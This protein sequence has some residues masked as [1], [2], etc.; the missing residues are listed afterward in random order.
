[1]RLASPT[2]TGTVTAPFFNGDGSNLTNIIATT[3]ENSYNSEVIDSS[4]YSNAVYPTYVTSTSGFSPINV[5]RTQLSF[6]PNSGTLKTNW[7]EG[8]LIGD[9]S[10]AFNVML[11]NPGELLYQ[12]DSNT[13]GFVPIGTL[14][15]V[16]QSNGA[17][18]PSWINLDAVTVDVPEATGTVKGGIKIS[19]DLTGSTY[20]NLTIGNDKITSNK[21]L[22]S[23]VTYSKIQNVSPNRILGNT[24]SSST[25]IQ[26]VEVTGTGKVALN[27]SPTFIN[28]TLGNATAT[29]INTTGL[30][31]GYKE[32]STTSYTIKPDD[33]HYINFTAEGS[34]I[35]L[36]SAVGI[37]GRRF[38]LTANEI[39]IVFFPSNSE[40]INGTVFLSISS[41]V[42]N[43][44][45]ILYSNGSNWMTEY[46]K[47]SN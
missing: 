1:V 33:A 26:E 3:S 20:D 13:T 34:M 35:T 38:V 11:G 7:F 19:G 21:I 40:K 22:D 16:L 8:N 31:L 28:P 41:S 37:A 9:A 30:T 25:S 24:S 45:L 14:G 23:N 29:T 46:T 39:N 12:A 10:R 4:T 15:Q 43:L 44:V 2:F 17:A 18:A 36:P 32:V 6:I 27:D 47:T 5:A 42:K